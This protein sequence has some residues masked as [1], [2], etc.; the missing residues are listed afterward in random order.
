MRSR[1][2]S[3]R[4]LL[5][6]IAVG[7]F[8]RA[9]S[10]D[11]GK[12]RTRVEKLICSNP[13]LSK[14]DDDLAAK[15][16]RAA[17]VA[18]KFPGPEQTALKEN[19]VTWLKTNVGRCNDAMCINLAYSDRISALDFYVSEMEGRRT[20][21]DDPTG[22]YKLVREPTT[23][24]LSVMRL[25]NGK[26]RFAF[27]LTAPGVHSPYTGSLDATVPLKNGVA[28]W[29]DPEAKAC[30]IELRFSRGSVTVEQKS[31]C[32]SSF[33]EHVSA[34]GVYEKVSGTVPIFSN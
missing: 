8:A 1:H 14:L 15:Y 19:Q 9:A 2:L 23:G 13:E 20:D 27:I 7:C 3:W 5:A 33:N 31:I 18:A 30:H 34:A 10:F 28:E 12:A 24:D 26:V 6:L 17:A 32:E 16:K 25:R 22:T 11:C 29:T 4:F 21:P